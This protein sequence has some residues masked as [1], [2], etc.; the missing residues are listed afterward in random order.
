MRIPTSAEWIQL[1][2]VT[3]G[4]DTIIHWREMFS[5]GRNENPNFGMDRAI[6]GYYEP[7]YYRCPYTGSDSINVGLRPAFELQSFNGLPNGAGWLA[8]YERPAS[9]GS[10]NPVGN[11]DIP[12]FP[13][14]A[15]LELRPALDDPAYQVRAIKVGNVLVADRAL[16]ASVT[17][18]E[19]VNIS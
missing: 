18:S 4:D 9:Q 12:E 2:E 19:A 5:F 6:L 17:W 13:P 10:T 1:L 15:K 11:V 8:L 3:D 14:D 7:D 16:V